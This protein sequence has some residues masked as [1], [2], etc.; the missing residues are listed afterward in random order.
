MPFTTKDCQIMKSK[1]FHLNITNCAEQCPTYEQCCE[2]GDTFRMEVVANP[3]IYP[4][5]YAEMFGTAPISTE[6]KEGI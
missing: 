2:D 5:V 6:K 1:K 4:E 3:E